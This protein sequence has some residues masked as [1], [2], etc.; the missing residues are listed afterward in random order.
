MRGFCARA[1][2]MRLHV[3]PRP[4]L[5]KICGLPRC[6][7]ERLVRIPLSSIV[8]SGLLAC[9]PGRSDKSEPPKGE[10]PPPAQPS[11]QAKVQEPTAPL[12]KEPTPAQ[13]VMRGHFE[14]AAQAREAL[15]RADVE[16]AKKAMAWLAKHP[17]GAVLPEE[18]H[19]LQEAMQQSAAEFDQ[20]QTLREAGLA[21]ARTL[22]RCG[23]CHRRSG[24]GP[25]FAV[26]P[27]PQGEDAIHHMQRH[28][29]AAQRMWE[30]LVKDD[31]EAFGSAAEALAEGPVDVALLAPPEAKKETVERLSGYLHELGA[32]AESANDAASRA[33]TYGKFLAT[34][35][36]CHRLLGRGPRPVAP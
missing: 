16:S 25:T 36:T 13:A 10:Q 19:P 20:A 5:G 33:E 34:C 35:A 24:K 26:P 23:D 2:D 17:L 22:T 4:T 12:G 31:A 21:L 18:L 14:H 3:A 27:V 6:G 7:Y 29:W 9:Q 32:S 28:H 15:L 1:A 11:A 30:A 8:L